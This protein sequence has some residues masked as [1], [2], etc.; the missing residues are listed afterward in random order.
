[1][2]PNFVGSSIADVQREAT[3]LK[4]RLSAK[5]APGR[6]GAVLRQSPKPGVAV[7][8]RHARHARGRGRLTNVD[9]V[10]E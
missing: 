1:M 7:G 4:V 6:A 8:T 5:T 9:P 10:S 2:L 3:R